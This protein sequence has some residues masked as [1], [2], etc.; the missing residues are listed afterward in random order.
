M[1]RAAKLRLAGAGLAS[2]I[3]IA[4]FGL[5]GCTTDEPDV[6]RLE[7]G[8]AVKLQD[9][10]GVLPELDCSG[11][12]AAVAAGDVIEC[13]ATIGRT[14]FPIAIDEVDSREQAVAR[15]KNRLIEAS[16]VAELLGARLSDEL[17]DTTIDCGGP[18]VVADDSGVI[19]ACTAI[20]SSGI[21]RELELSLS[22]QGSVKVQLGSS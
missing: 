3:M 19:R 11:A 13:L 6:T 2:A 21:V 20:D 8:L 12:N 22:D 15:V 18:L 5:T 16:T 4:G 9:R 7:Q 17:G 14:T 10:I 1:A